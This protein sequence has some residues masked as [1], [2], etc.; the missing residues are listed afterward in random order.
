MKIHGVILLIDLLGIYGIAFVIKINYGIISF[1]SSGLED[2]GYI[3]Q[4]KS[5]RT[6]LNIQETY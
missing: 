2:I 5:T 6:H 4:S 3:S 1:T